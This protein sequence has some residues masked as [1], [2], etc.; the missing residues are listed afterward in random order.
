[1]FFL[2]GY[3]KKNEETVTF[4][5]I[6]FPVKWYIYLHEWLIMMVNVGK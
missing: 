6:G 4:Q 2:G 1:M 3:V 5:P